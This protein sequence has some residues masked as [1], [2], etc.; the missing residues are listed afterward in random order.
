M[1]NH[2]Q[3]KSKQPPRTN[4]S[5]EGVRARGDAAEGPATRGTLSSGYSSRSSTGGTGGG[6]L[7]QRGSGYSPGA[8]SRKGAYQNESD[9]LASEGVTAG[10]AGIAE[11]RH[12]KPVGE[13]AD[14]EKNDEY[15]QRADG[16]AAVT[17]VSGVSGGGSG[18]TSSGNTRK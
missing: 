13:A 17:G 10:A 1:A 9:A 16:A 7:E 18:T 14:A 6:V 11:D 12:G 2:S 4:N 5:S 8:D 3:D 15:A